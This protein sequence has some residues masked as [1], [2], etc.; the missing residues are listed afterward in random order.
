MTHE[1]KYDT[2]VTQAWMRRV[3][4]IRG[5]ASAEDDET[6]AQTMTVKRCSCGATT[7]ETLEIPWDEWVAEQEREMTDHKR[8]IQP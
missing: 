2:T 1:H 3:N 8:T 7:T 5:A 4:R 6:V